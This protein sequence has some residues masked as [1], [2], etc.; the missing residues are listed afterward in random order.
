MT[1]SDI[2]VVGDL[3]STRLFR[4]SL[5]VLAKAKPLAEASGAALAMILIGAGDVDPSES[6]GCA[7]LDLTGACQEAAAQG[8]GTVY[9]LSHRHLAV[10]RTD[11]YA[12]VL[13][14]FARQREPWLVLM[15]LNDFNRE[16]AAFCAQHCRAGM[17]ADCA[18]LDLCEG[19]IIGRCPAWGGQ[20]MADIT[21]ADEWPLAFMTVQPHGAAV[22][23]SP[24]AA[25]RIEMIPL[26]N[27]IPSKKLCMLARDV[28]P[29]DMRRLEEAAKVVV[30]GAG[31]G[32]MRGFG[33]VRELAGALGAEVAAT[34]PPVLLHWI[35][36]DRLIGQTGKNIHP[37]L[38]ISVGTSGAVQY[39]A[40]IMEAGTIV[41]VDR[42]PKA[43]IFQW[44]DLGIV[45][46][47]KTLLPILTQRVQQITLRRL[48]DAACALDDGPKPARGGFGSLIRQLRT[49]RD[50]SVEEL[51]QR[52]GQTPD[53][54]VQVEEERLSPPVGFILNM[55]QSMQVDPG[56][57]L[58]R[59]EQTA[60]RDRRAQA[61]YRRTHEYSYAT[62]TPEAQNNHLRAFMVTIEPHHAHKPVAYKHEGEEFIYVLEGDL[63]F[64]LDSRAHVLKT[65]E[66]IHFNS[67][68]PHKLKSLSNTPTRC[69]VVLYTI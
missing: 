2:W 23:V 45:A 20:I 17:I 29:A 58:R 3:R 34:R 54:I 22:P 48:T 51:A 32:D 19:R 6:T 18:E 61:Y 15:A 11:L 39:T 8:A 53:F 13:A 67:D 55:A 38:L 14:D 43:P 40:G 24:A 59:E 49:A 12:R 27:V 30:G 60:L 37:E 56:T 42:D 52:T 26:E 47:A 21:L 68:V 65:G 62:L 4:D 28:A 69:L 35:E 57:F 64:T 36:E 50:W 66:S 1:A 25:G 63:E 5:K 46:D 33:L 9:G 41:A 10:A 16:M 31:L 44:A 7:P